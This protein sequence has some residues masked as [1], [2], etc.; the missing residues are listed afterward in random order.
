MTGAGKSGSAHRVATAEG[1]SESIRPMSALLRYSWLTAAPYRLS[2][3]SSI[4]VLALVS[5]PFMYPA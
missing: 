5:S 3:K 4:L 2:R 1:L